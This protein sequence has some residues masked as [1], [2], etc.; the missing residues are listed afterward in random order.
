MQET[1]NSL[2]SDTLPIFGDLHSIKIE[3]ENWRKRR[4]KSYDLAYIPESLPALLAP[5]VRLEILTWS[6][7]HGSELGLESQ[8]WYLEVESY[9]LEAEDDELIPAL[10]KQVLLPAVKQQLSKCWTPFH[11]QLSLIASEM[12]REMLVYV[13][14]EDPEMQKLLQLTQKKLTAA[15]GISGVPP[16]PKIAL[17]SSEVVRNIVEIR[18]YRC[19]HLIGSIGCFHDVL[20]VS[21]LQKLLFEDLICINM[22]PYLRGISTDPE[23]ALIKTLKMMDLIPKPWISQSSKCVNFEFVF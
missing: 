5:F 12:I 14:M 19:L 7:F 8:N 11:F 10:V 20:P 16:Y 1:G 4:R 9:G 21:F 22:L 2:F 6:P 3:F 15:V 18:F 13:Q 23:N 17:M